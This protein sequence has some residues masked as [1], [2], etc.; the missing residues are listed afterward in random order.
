MY[1][2]ASTTVVACVAEM[3]QVSLV[4]SDGTGTVIRLLCR[5]CRRV[6]EE[7]IDALGQLYVAKHVPAYPRRERLFAAA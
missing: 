4:C 6:S 7:S 5:E 1:V 3:A 2:D